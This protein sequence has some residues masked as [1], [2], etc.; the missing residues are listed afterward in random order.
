MSM[1]WEK[2]QSTPHDYSFTSESIVFSENKDYFVND[3][4]E[5]GSQII[6]SEPWLDVIYSAS[7]A[8][9]C[10]NGGDIL[11]I[12][13]DSSNFVQSHSISSHTIC[14]IHPDKISKAQEWAVGKSNVTIITG[15]WYQ[16]K[17]DLN[18]YD[19]ILHN[20]EFTTDTLWLSSSVE[21]FTKSGTRLTFDNLGATGSYNP[22]EIS[23]DSYQEVSVTPSDTQTY[24]T[25]SIYYMPKKEF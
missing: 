4:F 23:T 20:R 22:W 5:S 13:F 19:G 2:I 12:G 8:Y 1:T 6:I 15:S 24:F 9:V 11:E 17:D 16:N 10:E 21:S 18:T 3:N 14:E 7:A 25:S